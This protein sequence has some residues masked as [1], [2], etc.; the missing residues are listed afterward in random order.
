ME[1][2]RRFKAQERER[3]TKLVRKKSE[4]KKQKRCL[5]EDIVD[6]PCESN[7]D[8]VFEKHVSSEIIHSD[9]F[10]YDKSAPFQIVEQ[11]EFIP[12]LVLSEVTQ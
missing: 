10:C 7:I 3:E 2:T 1:A 6:K 5:E 8:T 12:E 9:V 11:I 4:R